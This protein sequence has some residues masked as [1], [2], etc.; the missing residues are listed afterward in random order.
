MPYE[1][2]VTMAAKAPATSPFAPL[3]GR[4]CRQADEGRPQIGV[5]YL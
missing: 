4:R 5:K 3:A 2:L 1:M